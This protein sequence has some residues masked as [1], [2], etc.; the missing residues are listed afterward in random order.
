MRTAPKGQ[1][2]Q[3]GQAIFRLRIVLFLLLVVLLYG[4][5]MW[6]IQTLS[7]AEPDPKTI[8]LQTSSTAKPSIDKAL[9][10]KI[11]QLE[12]SNVTVQSLFNQARQN[13]F[14]E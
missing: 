14:R 3:L 11:K 8:A 13:P 2:Q 12:S 1:L 10:E 5:V 7:T 4:F 9:V 6:R